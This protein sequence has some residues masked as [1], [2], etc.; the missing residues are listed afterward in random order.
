MIDVL[1]TSLYS[2]S[3]TDE[4]DESLEVYDCVILNTEDIV[5]LNQILDVSYSLLMMHKRVICRNL[6]I[7]LLLL[8]L[9]LLFFSF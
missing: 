7:L 8:L 4:L 5:E 1:R 6:L 2:N 9:L 3:S